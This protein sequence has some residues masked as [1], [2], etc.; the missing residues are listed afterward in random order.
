MDSGNYITIT[1]TMSDTHVTLIANELSFNPLDIFN[2]ELIRLPLILLNS[3]NEMEKDKIG[4]LNLL[5]EYG[6]TRRSL[7]IGCSGVKGTIGLLFGFSTRGLH[8]GM[9]ETRWNGT[10][11]LFP[12]SI[13][14]EFSIGT[15]HSDESVT[16]IDRPVCNLSF[17]EIFRIEALSA[18]E[19]RYTEESDMACIDLQHMIRTIGWFVGL[20]QLASGQL[21]CPRYGWYNRTSLARTCT[22]NHAY[23]LYTG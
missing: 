13:G 21:H 17:F 20:V 10:R 4:K 7:R 23:I 8:V 11:R 1:L 14:V 18:G 22:W 6:V 12:T 16:R 9:E 2:Y 5:Q 19:S 15:I 3:L